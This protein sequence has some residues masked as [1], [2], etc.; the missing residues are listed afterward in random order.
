MNGRINP[1]ATYGN[2]F[3]DTGNGKQYWLQA[4]DWENEALRNG[5]RQEYTATISGSTQKSNT[6]LSMGYLTNE[7]IT[8][9]SDMQ[10]ITGRL[11]ADF[12]TKDWLTVGGNASF[13]NY[14]YNKL[15]FG[16]D[17]IGSGNI[18]S[19]IYG[20]APIYPVYLR[21]DQGRIV[22]DDQGRIQYDFGNSISGVKR[23][24]GGT[25]NAIF[26]NRNSVNKSKGNSFTATGFSDIRFLDNF[27][28]TL[29]VSAF[30][31]E[32][33]RNNFES[34]YVQSFGTSQTNGY[35]YVGQT[36]KF[37]YNMQQL[38]N[39]NKTVNEAHNVSALLGH[40]YYNSVYSYVDGSKTNVA[41][42]NNQEL[43]GAVTM[44]SLPY[45]MSSRYNIEGYFLRTMYDYNSKY[46][47]SASF[48]RDASS[49]FHQD[50]RW[51]NFWS[52]GGAW[53]INKE[54]W[55]GLKWMEGLKFKTSVGSQGNDNIGS[56]LYDDQ[57]SI[58]VN[59]NGEV[60]LTFNQK[61]NRNITWETNTNF[62]A[63]FEFSV[64]KERIS[65][66]LD[67]FYRQT[68]DMLYKFTVAPSNGYTSYWDNIGDLR[69]TGVEFDANIVLAKGKDFNWN[70]NLNI[71][72]V[73]NK[74]LSLPEEKQTLTSGKY[75]GYADDD[76]SFVSLYRFFIAEGLPLYSWYIPKYAG[77][78][79][80]GESM[81]YKDIK[82]ENGNI[83]GRETTVKPSEA[84]DYIHGSALPDLYGGF[85]TT[86]RYRCFD[87]S[88]NFNYQIG[89]LG[90][91]YGYSTLLSAP[92]SASSGNFHKDVYK[93]WSP[94]NLNS[95]MP[96]FRSGESNSQNARSD[97]FL[98]N[99]SFLNFQNM[100]IGYTLPEQLLQ[101]MDIKKLRLYLQCENIAYISAR[102]GF[103]PRQS[104][105][106]GVNPQTYS[107]VRTISMGIN[108]NF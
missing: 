60:S 14:K 22:R 89:G 48:R 38:L 83:T 25:G 81:W 68:S 88:V 76:A 11:K 97:R 7:G 5:F 100:N 55:Y 29:N 27:K 59:G 80:D 62:N 42:D 54:Q 95:T 8:D 103:D 40:E 67:Y 46:Y 23:G 34:A 32:Y 15:T 36:R 3:T 79:E 82:D 31:D 2:L 1:N 17:V 35:V 43:S 85:G 87:F 45:S 24:A 18:W 94:E 53:I 9:G 93:S 20:Q 92:S 51:G 21:D 96:R 98:T 56:Y 37:S 6:Y 52:L 10:R 71:T 69:N 84:T 4:D 28:L 58:G 66:T 107:P 102:R 64:L 50:N 108:L 91:D 106:G 90:Y 63:G 104:M 70:F 19:L 77:V 99:A 30:N 101:K 12:K 13:V 105:K 78:N 44:S 47:A 33:R 39:Y 75:K 61:G 86:L 74:I 73:N 49:R 72:T 26:A 41:F 65:G 16:D 57:Y